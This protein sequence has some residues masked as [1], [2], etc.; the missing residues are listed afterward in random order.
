MRADWES[1]MARRTAEKE[2]PAADQMEDDWSSEVSTF[3]ERTRG[4]S[5]GV[6][7]PFAQGAGIKG[8]PSSRNDSTIQ[9][10]SG[11]ESD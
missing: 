2:G 10:K 11:Q 1:A 5:G 4:K 8:T 3:F 6:K 9:E 7:S